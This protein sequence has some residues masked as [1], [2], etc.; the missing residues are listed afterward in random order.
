MTK[1]GRKLDK[2]FVLCNDD[3]MTAIIGHVIPYE[4]SAFIW[5][6]TRLFLPFCLAVVTMRFGGAPGWIKVMTRFL[7]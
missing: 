4:E 5:P 7:D 6:L 2:H 3:L 1:L